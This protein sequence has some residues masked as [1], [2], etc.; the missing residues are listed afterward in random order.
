MN[1]VINTTLH[2]YIKEDQ[3]DWPG[4]LSSIM[5]SYR[6]FPS[7]QSTKQSSFFLLVGVHCNLPVDRALQPIGT[8]PQ[9]TQEHLKLVHKNL[10]IAR[11]I[12]RENQLQAQQ[13][14]KTAHDKKAKE[15]EFHDGQKVCLFCSKTPKGMST[16]ADKKMG[17]SILYLQWPRQSHLQTSQVWHN[18]R[19]GILITCQ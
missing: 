16:K 6:A 4:V 17:W 8:L 13:K 12:D 10:H 5:M 7:T 9:T 14:N 15:P 11:E 2:Q 1:S 19:I 3:S 18:Q